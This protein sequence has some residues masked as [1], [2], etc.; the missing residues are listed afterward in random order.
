[1]DDIAHGI[2]LP[3]QLARDKSVYDSVVSEFGTEIMAQNGKGQPKIKDEH[4]ASPN[5]DRRKLGDL[6]FRDR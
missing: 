5:I 3:K 4:M 2:L 6:V 1:M